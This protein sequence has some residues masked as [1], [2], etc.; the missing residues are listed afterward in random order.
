MNKS[1]FADIEY[2]KKLKDEFPESEWWY[3]KSKDGLG[4]WSEVSEGKTIDRMDMIHAYPALTTDML[5]ERLPRK[6][7][8]NF[9]LI[10]ISE[11]KSYSVSY[12][13]LFCDDN[14]PYFQKTVDDKSLPNALAKM[15]I[16][17]NKSQ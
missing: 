14:R 9:K 16:W 15:L 7:E 6:I 13:N 11:E 3:K 17:I 5:L 1:N 4:E 8:E 2:S 12:C 10:I